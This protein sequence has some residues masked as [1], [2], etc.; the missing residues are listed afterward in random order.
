ML[1]SRSYSVIIIFLAIICSL[2]NVVYAYTLSYL[3]NKKRKKNC[4]VYNKRYVSQFEHWMTLE[5]FFFTILAFYWISLVYSSLYTYMRVCGTHI[6]IHEAYVRAHASKGDPRLLCK[7]NKI[8]YFDVD[9]TYITHE[10]CNSRV[11]ASLSV[12]FAK[13]S[14]SFFFSLNTYHTAYRKGG[15]GRR[16]R[17]VWIL[18]AKK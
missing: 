5:T 15:R 2:S 17:E 11:L 10:T 1:E 8:D 7:R 9:I 16:R 13:Y 14:L 6:T 4:T 18:L 3:K 12:Q